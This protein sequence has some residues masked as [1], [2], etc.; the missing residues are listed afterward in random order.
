MHYKMVWE[1]TMLVAAVG[2][3]AAFLSAVIRTMAG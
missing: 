3:G 2:F 1:V